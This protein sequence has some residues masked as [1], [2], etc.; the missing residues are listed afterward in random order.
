[1]WALQILFWVSIR[2]KFEENTLFVHGFI[3]FSKYTDGTEKE[4]KNKERF[5]V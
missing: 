2:N 1:M 4:D 5:G 3:T